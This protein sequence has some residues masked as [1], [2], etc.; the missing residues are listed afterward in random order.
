MLTP[1]IWLEEKER[2]KEKGENPFTPPPLHE[3]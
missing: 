1:P 3:G 2:K